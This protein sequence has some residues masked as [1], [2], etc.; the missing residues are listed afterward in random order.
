MVKVVNALIIKYRKLVVVRKEVDGKSSWI[1][2]GGK[3]E[4][5]ED[6]LSCIRREIYEELPRLT[7]EGRFELH[8]HFTGTFPNNTSPLDVYP[9]RFFGQSN[10][11]LSVSTLPS[12]RIKEAR[13]EDY[14]GLSK[15]ALSEVARKVVQSLKDLGEL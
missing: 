13:M 2:P 10:Y 8:G 11:N 9:Y 6:D 1:F 15:L 5:D 12:E 3:P 4:I 7:L 14:A